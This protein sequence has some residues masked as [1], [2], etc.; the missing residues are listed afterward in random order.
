MV[1]FRGWGLAWDNF[2]A[3]LENWRQQGD[4]AGMKLEK[5]DA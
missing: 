3:M 2:Q 5:V 4:F 1:L